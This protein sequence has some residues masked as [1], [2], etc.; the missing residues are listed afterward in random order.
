MI[1][2][3]GLTKSYGAF[4]ALKDIDL[5]VAPGE[6]VV[7]LG[8]SGAGKSTLLRCINR[9]TPPTRGDIQVDGQ[10]T[11]DGA[12]SLRR[13]RR[14]VAMIFQHYNVVPRLSVQKN[15]LTGRLGAVPSLLSWLQVFPRADIAI[16]RECLHRVE[17]EDKAELRTDTLSGGQKQRVGIA[18]A[19]AQQPKVILADEPVASL[20]PK[21][22]R[23]V[24]T[25]LK[26]ASRELGITVVCNL[27]QI[28][29]A[30]EFSERIVGVSSGRIVFD[31]A[32]D[33][34]SDDVLRCIYPGLEESGNAAAPVI[35]R[36]APRLR[37]F[38]L[39]E[40]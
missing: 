26:Q 13:L 6:F 21:T 12:T 16:A 31:G 8:P 34:L 11:S 1:R 2:I 37:D 24:L 35:D 20:D 18:R 5:D 3:R 7:I 19:L 4:D 14:S 28:D 10:Q 22:S 36:P 40:A 33:Q 15:V 9:L 17:L 30:R 38:A 25:Y 27:H 32:P 23:T 29:Y 39:E